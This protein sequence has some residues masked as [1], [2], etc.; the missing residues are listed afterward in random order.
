MIQPTRH[1]HHH[2]VKLNADHHTTTLP[3][4]S[5]NSSNPP[6]SASWKCHWGRKRRFFMTTLSYTTL[7]LIGW[8]VTGLLRVG[9]STHCPA[10][11]HTPALVRPTYT[12]T[13]G[14]S[15]PG[16]HYKDI[17]PHQTCRA[18]TTT[19]TT[20]ATTHLAFDPVLIIGRKSEVL[21]VSGV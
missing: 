6:L 19:T 10:L 12:R 3:H 8:P 18:T 17:K 13:H 11:P 2:Q 9:A 15:S 4:H 1:N 14:T 7:F 20:T 21:E 16:T 5:A